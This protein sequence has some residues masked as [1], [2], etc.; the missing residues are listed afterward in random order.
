[1]EAASQDVAQLFVISVFENADGFHAHSH[2]IELLS[3]AQVPQL[4]GMKENMTI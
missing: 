3:R 2:N 4:G 1:M